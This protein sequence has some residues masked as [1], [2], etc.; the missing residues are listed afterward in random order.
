MDIKKSN[1]VYVAADKTRNYYTVSKEKYNELL[2]NSVTKAYKK[3]PK[4]SYDKANL[5]AKKIEKSLDLDDR[6]ESIAKKNAFITPKDHKNNFVNNPK[7]R[8]LN[9]AKTEMG[10]I[11]KS[12]LDKVMTKLK[13]LREINQWK[14]TANT[15]DWFKQ[16]NNKDQCSFMVFDIVDFYPSITSEHLAKAITFARQ[17]VP[18]SA[19]D[20]EIILHSRKTFLFTNEKTWIKRKPQEIIH[21]M[22]RWADLMVLKCVS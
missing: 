13:Q 1:N 18:I 16:I 21:S 15:I 22:Y 2:T 8:L 11:S 3:A 5:E 20:E 10:H 9:P 12:I 19:T 7:C 17:Y 4:A 14:S 6:I